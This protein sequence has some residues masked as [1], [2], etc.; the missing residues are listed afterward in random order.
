[1]TCEELRGP[2]NCQ[3]PAPLAHAPLKDAKR[4]QGWR[5]LRGRLWARGLSKMQS[6]LRVVTIYGNQKMQTEAVVPREMPGA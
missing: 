4:G 3:A 2:M 6:R 1:M 5:A